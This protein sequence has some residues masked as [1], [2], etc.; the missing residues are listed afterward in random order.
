MKG[1]EGQNRMR[2]SLAMDEKLSATGSDG[3]VRVF[4]SLVVDFFRE[5]RSCPNERLW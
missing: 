2:E 3:Q 5:A 1:V 4:P